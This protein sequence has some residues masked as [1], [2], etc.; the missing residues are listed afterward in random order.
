MKRPVAPWTGHDEDGGGTPRAM[1]RWLAQAPT[2]RLPWRTTLFL[3]LFMVAG[4]KGAAGGFEG[5]PGRG[6]PGREVASD[7]ERVA[8]NG[9]AYALV[10][11]T[12]LLLLFRYRYPPV[13]L[14]GTT[15]AVLGYLAAGY[16][17]GPVFIGPAVAVFAAIA[18]GHRRLGWSA[19]AAF[20]LGQTLTHLLYEHLPPS[21]DAAPSWGQLLFAAAWI[22]A[23]V[24]GGELLRSRREQW[25]QQRAERAAAQRRR[26]DEERLRIARELHDVLAHSISVINVQAGVGLALLDQHPEKAREALTTIKGA[27]KEALGE[28]RQV[29]EALRTPGGSA[30][31]TP[32]PGLARLRELTDQA[33]SAGL[34]VDV[35]TEGKRRDVPPAAD[36][37]AFRIVQEALTNIVRHSGSRTARVLVSYDPGELRLRIDDDGPA[38]A[39]G[40][41]GGGNGLVGMRERAA[42]LGGTVDA[43]PRPDG[44]FRVLARLPLSE[45]GTARLAEA[46]D[47]KEGLK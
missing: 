14:F 20:A 32:A 10:I 18:A 23:V 16:V 3:T 42:A 1:P 45:G 11:A 39:G 22:A 28:V 12:G 25:A 13:A 8:P 2:D 27:S 19:V 15:T 34:T 43:G 35:T 24:A 37:A 26:A 29:L 38:T 17:Y 4:T 21:D 6:Y 36:L 40:E 7:L 46:T 31:R 44:G 9:W 30:P 33:A 47:G 5:G 41:T